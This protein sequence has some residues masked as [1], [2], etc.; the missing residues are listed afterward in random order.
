MVLPTL[1]LAKGAQLETKDRGTATAA[2]PLPLRRCYS[3]PMSRSTAVQAWVAVPDRIRESLKGL[4]ES[5]LDLRRGPEEWSI[6]ET[7]HHLAETHLIT[8]SIL[9]AALGASGST[10]DW[11]WLMPGGRV[12]AETGVQVGARR[13]RAGDARSAQ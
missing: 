8:S 10:Y 13:P 5:K 2:T 9:I 12:A 7:V 4:D 6:R 11:S 3:A 1:A